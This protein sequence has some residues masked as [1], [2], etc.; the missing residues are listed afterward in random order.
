MQSTRQSGVMAKPVRAYLM[1]VIDR[2]ANA[3]D[4]I[5][6]RVVRSLFGRMLPSTVRTR[7]DLIILFRRLVKVSALIGVVL[8]PAA[9]VLV[10]PKLLTI[11]GMLL[12]LAGL[13]RI[14][15]DEEWEDITALY[16]NEADFPYGPP[17]HITRE[18]FKDDN[19]DAMGELADDVET[20][21]RHLYWR[22]GLA[23]VL[24]GFA[25]QLIGTALS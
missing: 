4:G 19:P 10:S 2:A 13:A 18:M 20:M 6:A 5:E 16:A 8:V 12:E 24:I 1:G 21:A 9:G 15:I 3:Y 23:L 7:M 25:L 22:R 14:F 17:S 11:S